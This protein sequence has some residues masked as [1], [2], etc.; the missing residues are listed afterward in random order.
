MLLLLLLLLPTRSALYTTVT[1]GI[2]LLLL[3]L[4]IR[5]GLL[6]L[7]LRLRLLLLLWRIVQR[8]IVRRSDGWIKRACHASNVVETRTQLVTRDHHAVGN[9]YRYARRL[10]SLEIQIAYLYT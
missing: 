10:L 3:L 2:L 7:L 9:A 5:F 4:P 8:L 1:T 6:L